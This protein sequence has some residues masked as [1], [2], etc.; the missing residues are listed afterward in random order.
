MFTEVNPD[1]GTKTIRWL[2]GKYRFMALFTEVNPDKGTKTMAQHLKV[3]ISI[4]FTE[5]NPDKG[6]KTV[7]DVSLVSSPSS[8]G[9]QK[10]TPI[11]GRKHDKKSIQDQDRWVYRS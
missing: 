7:L 11:R 8:D 6:T 5:V 3:L 4:L 2:N 9:L 1:K 10:L